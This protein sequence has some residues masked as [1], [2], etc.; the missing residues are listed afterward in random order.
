MR[1][2]QRRI[3]N[4][5]I[6]GLLCGGS[7]GPNVPAAEPA[8]SNAP[9]G[10]WRWE[11]DPTVRHQR[12]EG[13]GASDAWSAQFVGRWPAPLRQQV[14][15]WLFSREFDE[16]GR[17]KGIGLSVWRFNLGAGS[18]EQGDASGIRDPWRRA[19]CFL[20][21][22]GSWDW[23]KQA[24]QQWFLQAARR[25]GVETVVAFVNSPPVHLTRNGHAWGDGSHRSNLAPDH[26][27]AFADFLGEVCAHFQRNG[28][29]FDYLSPVNEPQWSWSR[30]NGQEGCP[31]TNEEIRQLVPH[32]GR[33]LAVRGLATRL[34]LPEAGSLGHVLQPMPKEPWSSDQLRELY[35]DHPEAVLRTP[36][37]APVVAAHGYGTTDSRP[38]M[39]RARR[40]LERRL[41]EDHPGLRYWM[42]E[43]C[44]LGRNDEG[45]LRG[46][47][48]DL[49]ITPALFI[50]RVMHHDLTLADATAWHWWLA[51][52]PYD[53]KD[54]LVYVAKRP[55]PHAIRDSKML[56]ALGHYA[57]FI[58][59]GAQRI[60]LHP[61]PATRDPAADRD[62]PL[63]SAWLGANGRRLVLVGINPSE[64]PITMRL[65][66]ADGTQKRFRSYL[67]TRN[68]E[69]NLAPGPMLQT[70]VPWTLPARSLVTWLEQPD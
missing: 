68:P 8:K 51:I 1:S 29:R 67:T 26:D 49:G 15:T 23:S 7:W 9:L 32:L 19:E 42:S 43:Y 17:P 40:E 63:M 39:L 30:R 64:E 31:W 2:L 3:G 22:D 4:A 61:P 37:V 66:M 45:R 46:G 28:L 50:A 10:A 16:A 25:Y 55:D 18:A 56:W 6:A 52:S 70:G 20:Q 44:I 48:R 14:A 38:M 36:Q 47:G 21:A 35:G 33:A 60:G 41:R 58:R 59:P 34:V 5:I 57:R 69:Q 13:F 24:G 53:Y 12:I 65:A 11:I 62:S 54:G 27:D